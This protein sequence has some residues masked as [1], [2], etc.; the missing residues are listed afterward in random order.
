MTNTFSDQGAE[1]LGHAEGFVPRWY[2]D[3]T[4]TGTIGNGFTWASESFRKWWYAHRPGVEFGPGATISR[5]ESAEVLR[6]LVDEEYG[7][8]VNRAAPHLKQHEYDGSAG[9]VFNCG[10]VALNW[11]W[12]DALKRGDVPMAANLLETTAITSKGVPLRGLRIRRKE[13][14]D[15]IEF[16]DYSYGSHAPSPPDAMSDGVLVRGERGPDV[17]RLIFDLTRLGVYDGIPDD[18]FG[19]GTEA[20]VMAFQRMEG[21]KADGYAGPKTLE[22]IK[23]AVD[24]LEP[25]V[26]KRPNP[27]M[28]LLVKI[29]FYLG[30]KK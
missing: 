21:L 23:K 25:V 26:R 8:A 1:F 3:P 5:K 30:G 20:A 17:A 22:A 13:E 12:F 16:A 10:G 18:V 11:D 4:G 6:I 28:D 19:R 15:L 27:F 14:A 2:K 7:A 29:L 9:V 24:D